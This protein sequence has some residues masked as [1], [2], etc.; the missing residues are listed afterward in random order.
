LRR[1]NSARTRN[2]LEI[3][4]RLGRE[5][6]GGVPAGGLA[7]KDVRAHARSRL[8]RAKPLPDLSEKRS[9]FLA[10]CAVEQMH[11]ER[12]KLPNGPI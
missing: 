6:G 9:S 8:A 3:T 1:L 5:G 11:P 12:R 10:A 7:S 2:A 4:R